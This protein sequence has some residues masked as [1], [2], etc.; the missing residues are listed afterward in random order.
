MYLLGGD[1]VCSFIFFSFE[2]SCDEFACRHG[3]GYVP[4]AGG[5]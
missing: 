1:D 2:K 5:K 4:I 3:M